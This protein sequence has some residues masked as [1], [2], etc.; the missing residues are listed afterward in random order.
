MKEKT[1]AGIRVCA[2]CT[3]LFLTA[4]GGGGGDSGN[5]DFGPPEQNF[6]PATLS[7]NTLTLVVPAENNREITFTDESNWQETRESGTI[8]GTYSYQRNNGQMATVNLDEP[9]NPQT[10]SLNFASPTTGTITYT[11]GRAGTG[12]FT[13]AQTQP[14]E[15]PPIEPP[16]STGKAPS[17]LAGKTMLG[18]RT[19]TSTGPVGQTHTYTF[20]ANG[21]HDSDPPEESDGRYNYQPSGDTAALDLTYTNPANFRGDSHQMQLRFDTSSTG[22]FTSTY[23]RDDGTVIQING[24]FEIQ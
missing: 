23:T 3:V 2:L 8:T 22:A 18:T 12:T 19:F 24:T 15:P 7:G 4:C 13:L 21:F 5:S 16:P 6:T 1:F 11:A 14:T 17:S 10:I 9:G 20:S